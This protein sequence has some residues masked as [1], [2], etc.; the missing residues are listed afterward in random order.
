M[1][2][3]DL[4]PYAD[5]RRGT[6]IEIEPRAKARWN[7]S[8]QRQADQDIEFLPS[9]DNEPD[10]AGAEDDAVHVRDWGEP[11]GLMIVDAEDFDADQL[12]A[13]E[14]DELGA[15]A[16]AEPGATDEEIEEENEE[17]LEEILLRHYGMVSAEPE[18][19][20]ALQQTGAAEFVCRSCF[21]RKPSSQLA[22]PERSICVDC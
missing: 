11:R 14:A 5:V 19:E 7:M 6:S 3:R 10:L 9:D 2:G 12:E 17:D 18:G 8:V 21:L 15:E 1:A 13:E 4:G 20:P 16:A 22:D